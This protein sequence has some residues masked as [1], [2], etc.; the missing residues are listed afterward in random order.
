M[1]PARAVLD[2]CREAVRAVVQA[3]RAQSGSVKR[4]VH[5]TAHR[6]GLHERRVAAYWWGEAHAVP[7]HEADAIRR[8][9]A[10]FHAEAAARLAA[11]LE[12]HRRA[13][14]AAQDAARPVLRLT[15]PEA[16]RQ[17]GRLPL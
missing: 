1:T 4:A 8:A 13:K 12:R 2:E 17:Q 9:A 3:E 6:L 15:A 7:A 5:L 14:R 11:D 10:A 16:P